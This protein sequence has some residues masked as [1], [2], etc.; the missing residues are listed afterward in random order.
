MSRKGER[1][2]ERQRERER[3][4]H[5]PFALT[6]TVLQLRTWVVRPWD[7]EHFADRDSDGVGRADVGVPVVDR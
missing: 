7:E 4:R 2:R 5:T 3:E 1:E 6:L